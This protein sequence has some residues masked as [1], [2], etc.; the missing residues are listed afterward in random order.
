MARIE[1]RQTRIRRIRAHN[2]H[3]K[4]IEA[5]ADGN[6][7]ATTPSSHYSVG[8]TENFPEHIGQFVQRNA[9]DPAIQV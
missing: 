3:V 1:R 4:D 5:M 8:K 2:I 7:S 9:G 6:S